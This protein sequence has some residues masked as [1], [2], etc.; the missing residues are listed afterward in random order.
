MIN[1]IDY[2]EK[3]IKYQSISSISQSVI[4]HQSI[5]SINLNTKISP[6]PI[7]P[8]NLAAKISPKPKSV[9]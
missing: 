2:V 1:T 9:R 7:R 6:N 5:S 4:K 3:Y 8:V